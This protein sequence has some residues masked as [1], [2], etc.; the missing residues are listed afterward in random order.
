MTDETSAGVS[1]NPAS[2]REFLLQ[3][4][5]LKDVSF[6]APGAP[7]V[8]RAN[9]APEVSMNLNTEVHR[10]DEHHFEVVLTVTL[11]AQI[12]GNTA[13]L[14]EAKQAGIFL[15]RGFSEQELPVMFGVHCPGT[16]FPYVREVI[17]DLVAK[18]SFPQMALQPIS[19][20]VL[21][22]QHQAQQRAQTEPQTTTTH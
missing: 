9:W 7:D 8:F 19:F 20:E 14:V 1:A 11:S 10:L 4:I 18:G 6:E 21:F 5:Y 22:A 13:Y 16:L 15:L 2:G 17:G 12:E 3:R